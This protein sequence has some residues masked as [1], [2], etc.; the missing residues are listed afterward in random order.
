MVRV[1]LLFKLSKKASTKNESI[2]LAYARSAKSLLQTSFQSIWDSVP[3][4]YNEIS[5]DPDAGPA[6]QM[7]YLAVN[8]RFNL[9]N[10]IA[11]AQ[12]VKAISAAIRPSPL[13]LG[14]IRPTRFRS[15]SG[16]S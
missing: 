10:L 2:G 12:Q 9:P 5:G 14:D 7:S 16:P 15:S 13:L 8:I 6:K 3:L 11:L 1:K 4:D